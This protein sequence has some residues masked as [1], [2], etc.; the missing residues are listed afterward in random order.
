MHQVW[1][2]RPMCSFICLTLG[3]HSDFGL[4]EVRQE[5]ETLSAAVRND[6]TNGP[7]TGTMRWMSPERLRGGKLDPKVDVYAYGMTCYEA[8][9]SRQS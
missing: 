5:S 4:S 1:A 2:A 7:V 8:R 6:K 9:F 3:H